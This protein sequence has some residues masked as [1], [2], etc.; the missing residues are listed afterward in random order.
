MNACYVLCWTWLLASCYQFSIDN[1]HFHSRTLYAAIGNNNL[2]GMVMGP[3]IDG[4]GN[5]A[6]KM[7]CSLLL[8]TS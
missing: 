3:E 6:E 4:L 2:R 5:S 1:P 8:F 7:V